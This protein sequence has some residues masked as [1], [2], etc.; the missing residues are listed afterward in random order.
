MPGGVPHKMH[1]LVVFVF[2][3]SD[4]VCTTPTPAIKHHGQ[5]SQAACLERERQKTKKMWFIVFNSNE[6]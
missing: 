2:V 4:H 3:I 1:V 5:I 6:Y